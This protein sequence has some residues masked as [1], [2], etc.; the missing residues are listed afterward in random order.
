MKHSATAC[1]PL[2]QWIGWSE[3]EPCTDSN[4]QNVTRTICCPKHVTT[5]E[6]CVKECNLSMDSAGKSQNCK[7]NPPTSEIEHTTAIE[8]T[9][10]ENIFTPIFETLGSDSRVRTTH[11]HTEDIRAT[12]PTINSDLSTTE[13]S[14]DSEVTT[15]GMSRSLTSRT[16]Y[17]DQD[18]IQETSTPY[19][20]GIDTTTEFEIISATTE[21]EGNES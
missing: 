19:T 18:K 16:T 21:L 20:T 2:C 14:M 1:S 17:I 7:Y 13:G 12:I 4:R 10:L 11:A 8:A 6:T 5:L 15:D 9:L 3:P